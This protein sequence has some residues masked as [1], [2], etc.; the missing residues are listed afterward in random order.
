MAACGKVQ[1]DDCED[2]VQVVRDTK[3]VEVPCTRNTYEKYTVQVPRQ[4]TQQIPRTVT[5]TDYESRQKQVPY[6]VNRS[7]RRVRMQTEKYQV[8]VTKYYKRTVTETRERQVPVPYYANAPEVKYLGVIESVP[9]QKSKVGIDDMA[10]TVYDTQMRADGNL[11]KTVYDTQMRADVNLAKTGYDSQMRTDGNLTKTVY[12]SQMQTDGNMRKAV[13]DTQMRSGGG[14]TN[15]GYDTQMRTGGSM[16]NVG[17]GT[18][19]GTGGSVTNAG[20][21]TQ[22]GTGGSMTNAGYGTQ[23]GTGGSMTNVGYSNTQMPTGGIPQTNIVTKQS[24]VYNEVPKAALS[25]PRGTGY[26]GGDE[27]A[28]DAVAPPRP[29]G[30]D[31]GGADKRALDAVALPR[32][33]GT[34]YGG[35]GKGAFDAANT[36]DGGISYGEFTAARA[37]SNPVNGS[38]RQPRMQTQKYQV[39]VTKYYKRTVME[40]RERQVPVPYYVDVPETKYLTVTEKVPVQKSKV[41]MDNV[42]KTVYEPQMRTRCVPRTKMVKKQI[43]VYNVVPKPAPPCPPG[44]DCGGDKRAFDAVDANKDGVISFDEFTAARAAGNP[45]GNPV[46]TYL[47]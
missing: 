6:T 4:V 38:V 44:T 17:Y 30:T 27:R 46:P 29:R 25:L 42:T 33:R 13:Y 10:K 26:G 28:F 45:V 7:E 39:P 20:Y 32:P 23:M 34:D 36:K 16:T 5:Y 2:C 21:G 8:P 11:A 37:A 3:T 40:T 43:P 19:I 41:E 15:A 35:G 12:D 18:Q 22:M 1:T 24:P 14:I 47:K 31:F 9:V